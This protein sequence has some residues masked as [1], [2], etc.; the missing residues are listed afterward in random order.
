MSIKELKFL[1]SE[2]GE[3]W[4]LWHDNFPLPLAEQEAL[5]VLRK[6]ELQD[7]SRW[8]PPAPNCNTNHWSPTEEVRRRE[9]F[10]QRYALHSAADCKCAVRHA[11]P[12]KELRVG[13]V[14]LTVALPR[15]TA[16]RFLQSLDLTN[17]EG[18]STSAEAH[19]QPRPSSSRTPRATPAKDSAFFDTP[20]TFEE[21]VRLWL[22]GM[23]I[24]QE[25]AD[26]VCAHR[27]VASCIR[28]K[29][30]G[31]L[32]R[33]LSEGLYRMKDPKKSLEA[34]RM[35]DSPLEQLQLMAFL[36]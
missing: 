16:E 20:L 23:G 9:E 1:A 32:V 36:R 4:A 12:E 3:G 25:D 26:V 8:V 7:Y 17:D 30:A 18:A 19:E 24:S 6:G 28:D 31:D 34:V 13:T 33:R 29:D 11:L 27:S 14:E 22:A 10:C 15:R 21:K 35:L 2:V 5:D